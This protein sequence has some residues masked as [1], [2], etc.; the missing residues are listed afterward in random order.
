MIDFERVR[1]ARFRARAEVLGLTLLEDATRPS[2][3][4]RYALHSFD[5]ACYLVP[6]DR[7]DDET[8]LALGEV[9][10]IIEQ[11]EARLAP[12]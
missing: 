1:V 12:A 10:T 7:A 4:D 8:A 11:R 3:A 2:A 9:Q 6:P 5:L